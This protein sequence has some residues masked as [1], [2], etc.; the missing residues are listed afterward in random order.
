M[1]R[2]AYVAKFQCADLEF[3]R[4]KAGLRPALTAC[5]TVSAADDYFAELVTGQEEFQA[6]ETVKEFFQAPIVED[7]LR[8]AVA[9][10]GYEQSFGI[11]NTE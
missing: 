3:A 4:S 9:A 6:L 2:C 11:L 7:L 1:P 8:L 5:S 10:V